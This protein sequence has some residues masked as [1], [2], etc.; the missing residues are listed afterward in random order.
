GDQHKTTALTDGR[1]NWAPGPKDIDATPPFFVDARRTVG[2]ATSLCRNCQR[3]RCDRRNAQELEDAA[4]EKRRDRGLDRTAR[5]QQ[6]RLA[7]IL[8]A[9]AISRAARRGNRSPGQ[10]PPK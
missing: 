4:C 10:Q 7:T 6:R 5:A 2:R 3:R 1:R 8:D 9:G